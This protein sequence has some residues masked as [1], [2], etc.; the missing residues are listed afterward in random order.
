[1][2]DD[3]GIIMEY[4]GEFKNNMREGIGQCKLKN[5]NLYNFPYSL[6]TYFLQ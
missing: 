3:E 4:M 6:N 5:G 2:Y 1:M